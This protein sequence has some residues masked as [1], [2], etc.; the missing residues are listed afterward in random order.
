LSRRE[1]GLT[2]LTGVT[3][4]AQGWLAT[5]PEPWLRCDVPQSAGRWVR[6]E[7]ASG[8]LDPLTRPALRF[9]GRDNI[10]DELLPAAM[11]GRGVWIGRLPEDLREVWISP[12]LGLGPFA[13]RIE[14]WAILTPLRA[15]SHF[16]PAGMSRAVKYSWGRLRGWEQFARLQ[17][18]RALGPTPLSDYAQ[19]RRA[20]A[21]P[22]EPAFDGAGATP[23][24]VFHVVAADRQ[25]ADAL[26][27]MLKRQIWPHWTLGL[28][29]ERLEA[30]DADFVLA[31]KAGDRLEPQ[32]LAQLAARAARERR[33]DALYADEDA[34]VRQAR[35]APRLKPDWSPLFSLSGYAGAP[36]ALSRAA[37]KAG[38]FEP[39]SARVAHVRRVAISRAEPAPVPSPPPAAPLD[40]R[41]QVS[42]IVPTRDRPDLIGACVESLGRHPLGADFELIVIDNGSVRA[43]ALAHLET[44]ASAPNVRVLR[45][46]GPFNFSAICNSGAREARYPFLLFLNDD[47]EA[48]APDWLGRLLHFAA[49]PE[50]GA[51]GAKLLYPDGRLQHG[52][53]VLGLDGFAGH[54]QRAAGADDP[55]YLGMLAWPREVA[56]VTGACLAVEARKFFEVGGFDEER[57]PIEYNDIDLCLR[58]AERGY[59]SVFEPRARLMHRESASR[60][61]NPWLD[62]RYASEHGYFRERWGRRLRDDPYFHPALSLDALEIALG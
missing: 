62:S 19:W 29:G 49:A 36:L 6:F 16:G 12:Q 3:A 33:P 45:R 34:L 11:L 37:W 56:A 31:L 53:V 38:G 58:L 25:A 35:A 14:R 52:G 7:Y 13:F 46:P 60:G 30:D 27:P 18:R 44:L 41:R 2:A 23:R 32:A 8:L 51:V 39:V 5:D 54:V 20:R 50:V 40:A 21:R 43:E 1:A 61:A 48:L 28:A 4:T 55:G 42:I 24:T 22:F 57:L 59:T 47:V 26:Q 9:I 10:Y 15:L 17:A